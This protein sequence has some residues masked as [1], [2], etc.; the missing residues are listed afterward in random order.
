MINN[1]YN[2]HESTHLRLFFCP[3]NIIQSLR[4]LFIV[5]FQ[6]TDYFFTP[7][8]EMIS[9][10]AHQPALFICDKELP[11]LNEYNKIN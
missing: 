2:V 5:L 6:S 9:S 3:I 4:S 8:Q 1:W 7:T 10:G 11:V